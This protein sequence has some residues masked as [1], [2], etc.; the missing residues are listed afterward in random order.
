MKERKYKLLQILPVGYDISTIVI[1]ENSV[2][3][4]LRHLP[5]L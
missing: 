4:S 5:I 1:S 2:C 3:L